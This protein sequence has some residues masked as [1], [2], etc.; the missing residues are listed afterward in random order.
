MTVR[1]QVT[2]FHGLG[3]FTN[4]NTLEVDITDGASESIEAKHYVVATGEPPR[5][6]IGLPLCIQVP[7]PPRYLSSRLTVMSL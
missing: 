5:T 3:R 4:A 2:Q 1:A 6:R 7:T